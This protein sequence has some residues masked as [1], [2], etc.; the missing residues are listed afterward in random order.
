METMDGELVYLPNRLVLESAITNFTAVESRRSML[1]VGLDYATDLAHAAEV[2]RATV[3]DTSGV[4]SDPQV[5]VFVHTFDDSTINA[6]IWFW[7]LPDIRTA[8]TVRSAV[9]VN[10]KRALDGAGI[11][12]AFPQRVLWRGDPGSDLPGGLTD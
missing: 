6:A 2:L 5:E 11:T 1:D 9:A 10:V 4:V 7:H 8:W 12:I 3:R